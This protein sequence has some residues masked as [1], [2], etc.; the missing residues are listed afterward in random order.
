[1]PAEIYQ[2]EDT[3][4]DEAVCFCR[5][6]KKV[7]YETD[8]INHMRKEHGTIV[9]AVSSN[10]SKAQP[11][12]VQKTSEPP[13]WQQRPKLFR[14]QQ[15]PQATA[16]RQCGEM[17]GSPHDLTVHTLVA[18]YTENSAA[19]CGV[20][21]KNC[22]SIE[23]LSRHYQLVHSDVENA[24]EEARMLLL[25]TMNEDQNEY[26]EEGSM[27]MDNSQEEATPASLHCPEV[28]LQ[29]EDGEAEEEG[30]LIV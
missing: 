28:V 20:C 6:C 23:F 19:T 22:S 11:V 8:Y 5:Q 16:C 25:N 2:R 14:P 12:T 3:K 17:F 30:E 4:E 9:S 24:A 21:R 15:Q 27:Y 18:H 13:T 26:D 10:R 29:E 1:M 7:F